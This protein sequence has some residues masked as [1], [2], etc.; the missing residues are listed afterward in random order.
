MSRVG[1]ALV[2]FVVVGC[3]LGTPSFPL[4]SGAVPIPTDANLVAASTLGILCNASAVVPAVDGY[5]RGDPA[6]AAWP[7]WLEAAGG[8]HQ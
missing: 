7:V 1:L 2:S 3:G 4:L 5:L 6:D 8:R